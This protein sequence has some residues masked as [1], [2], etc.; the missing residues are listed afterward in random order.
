M[1][2]LAGGHIFFEPIKIGRGK[3]PCSLILGE[4]TLCVAALPAGTGYCIGGRMRHTADCVSGY[5]GRVSGCFCRI[6]C[7]WRA[8]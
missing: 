1:L 5:V 7:K 6:A 8:C 3:G 2:S 4:G